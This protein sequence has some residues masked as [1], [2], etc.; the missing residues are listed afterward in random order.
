MID[1]IAR[2]NIFYFKVYNISIKL[3]ELKFSE[4]SKFRERKIE[5]E[6]DDFFFLN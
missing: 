2:K 4:I 5:R 1:A 6:S 3:K